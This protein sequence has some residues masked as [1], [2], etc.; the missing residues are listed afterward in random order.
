[1]NMISTRTTRAITTIITITEIK[2]IYILNKSG[3]KTNPE[4]NL[5]TCL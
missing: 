2:I 3:F 4:S 5:E 1:M